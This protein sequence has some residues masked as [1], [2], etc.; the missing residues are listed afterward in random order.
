MSANGCQPT[1]TAFLQACGTLGI[2]QAFTSWNNLEGSA[3]TARVM[4]TLNGVFLWLQEWT[5]SFE[6]MTAIESGIVSY[7]EPYVHSALGYK[8][9]SGLD[10]DTTP[11]T[12]LS[13]PTLD[14]WGAFQQR[15]WLEVETARG[16]TGGIQRREVR[17][18]MLHLTSAHA[19]V[20][21]E[22]VSACPKPPFAL[23]YGGDVVSDA[24]AAGRIDHPLLY[25]ILER[26]P[27]SSKD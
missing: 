18:G 6:L 13:S 20:T 16:L 1:A 7:T 12:A 4:R 3:G 25:K 23:R 9:P 8:P 27:V 15:S 14:E 21:A 2:Q 11:A 19:L 24:C 10:G 5:G 22:K 17:E 26:K